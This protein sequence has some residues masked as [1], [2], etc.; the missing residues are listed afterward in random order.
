MAEVQGKKEKEIDSI[1][2]IV[3]KPKLCFTFCTVCNLVIIFLLMYVEKQ[4]NGKE[5]VKNES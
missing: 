4:R 2:V 5:V 3:F 1:Q